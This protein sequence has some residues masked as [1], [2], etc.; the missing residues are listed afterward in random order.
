MIGDNMKKILLL[1][2]LV[3]VSKD[4]YTLSSAIDFLNTLPESRQVEAKIVTLNSQ[5]A[6]IFNGYYTV[7]YRRES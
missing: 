4:F 1:I 7:V 6:A 2:A 3:W 5:R